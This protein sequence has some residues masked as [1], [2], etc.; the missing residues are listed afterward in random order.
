[1]SGD[2]VIIKLGLI[3]DNFY[4][5][6]DNEINTIVNK[7]DIY[8]NETYI[9]YYINN[10]NTYFVVTN[11]IFVEIHNENICKK[12][13]ITDI[14]NITFDNNVC[15]LDKYGNTYMYYINNS[16]ICETFRNLINKL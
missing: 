14:V 5:N 7:I 1:M 16:N 13:F 2:Y 4:K 6:T 9:Y 11:D 10:D 3:N 12:I 15:I 8:A